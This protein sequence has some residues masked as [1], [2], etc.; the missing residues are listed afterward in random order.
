MV[1][2]G[3]DDPL[4]VVGVGAS[5]GGVEALKQFVGGLPADLQQAVLVVLHVA[6]SAPSVLGQILD[7]C[8]PLPAA[9]ARDGEPVRAGHVYVAVPDRHLLVEDGR[10]RLSNGPTEDR[11]RPAVN[12]LFRSLA[13]AYGAR[14][15]G[16]VMSGVLD[17]GVLGLQAIGARGGTTMVQ[18]PDEAMYADMP[19]NALAMT[20]VHHVVSAAEAGKVLQSLEPDHGTGIAGAPDPVLELENEIAL[21]SPFGEF[22]VAR[23]GTPSGHTCPDC[24]GSLVSVGDGN[25]RCRIGHAWTP[26]A[27]LEAWTQDTENALGVALR[28]LLEKAQLARTHARVIHDDVLRSRYLEIADEADAA[29]RELRRLLGGTSSRVWGESRGTP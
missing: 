14:A 5:A 23:L 28:S 16:L 18:D 7:R 25:L 6:P 2:P 21:G 27:L 24:S 26:E 20:D 4:R 17:D 15:T 13:V 29:A 22:D 10:I 9:A 19:R 1:T 8:G 3:S 11:H 12:P